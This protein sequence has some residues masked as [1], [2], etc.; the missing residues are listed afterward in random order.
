[1]K[2]KYG[3]YFRVGDIYKMNV[4]E[5]SHTDHPYYIEVIKV[6][7]HYIMTNIPDYHSTKISVDNNLD[8]HLP[9]M[10]Y[11]GDKQTYGHL[12]LNQVGLYKQHEIKKY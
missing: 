4:G 11:V 10:E 12:I 5:R 3:R 8:Y 6:E 7:D 1:M 2:D 9:R